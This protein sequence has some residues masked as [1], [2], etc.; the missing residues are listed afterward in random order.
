MKNT[1]TTRKQR[2]RL[3]ILDAALLE[4]DTH[5]VDKVSMEA[6]AQRAGLTRATVYNL[7]STKEA[8]A[9]EIVNSKVEVWDIEFR[10]RM[11]SDENGLDLIVEALF[12]NSEIC[13]KHP[14]IAI[15]VM[16]KPQTSA[17][18][19][20]GS[21]RKSF[22][23]LIQDLIIRSQQQGLI[24]SDKEPLYLMFL[25]LGL[26]VQMMLFALSS[27]AKVTREQIKQMF[28]LLI[29]GIGEERS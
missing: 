22:R 10:K 8:I 13:Q 16:S 29:E 21:E 15:S 27:G 6:I 2:S 5:G 24:R 25:V 9:A 20:D 1:I 11:T 4:F 23:I 18:P 7:F 14:Y 17:L 19:E 26:Y 3:L 28:K 12:E